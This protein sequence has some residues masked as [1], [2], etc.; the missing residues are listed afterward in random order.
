VHYELAFAHMRQ[1]RLRTALGVMLI[2]AG[3]I[4]VLLA[5]ALGYRP[6]TAQ[7]PS[8]TAAMARTARP[9]GATFRPL[10]R[11][12][13]QAFLMACAAI[14]FVTMWSKVDAR[15]YEIGILRFLGA[16]RVLVIAIVSTEAA[17]VS[18]GGALLAVAASHS[19]VT[20]LNS[21]AA[22]T[23]AF[24]IGFKWCFGACS[25]VVGA[26]IG[27]SAIPCAVAVQREVI[28]MLERD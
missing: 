19:A 26:A 25:T 3:L 8:A 2:A 1:R 13:A 21:G 12:F 24:S 14:T 20:W 7:P 18:L 6:A 9:D 4:A 23:P 22:G 11:R 16:S 27:G 5:V 28:A 10:F 17:V 15:E